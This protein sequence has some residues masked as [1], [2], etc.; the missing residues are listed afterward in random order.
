MILPQLLLLMVTFG[1][2]METEAMYTESLVIDSSY[3]SGFTPMKGVRSLVECGAH[4]RIVKN[5]LDL[6]SVS[7][8]YYDRDNQTCHVGTVT[9][10]VE[11]L[12]GNGIT[13]FGLSRA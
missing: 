11:E 4:F 2:Q 6:P 7:A 9:F 8:F 3:F 13:V 10:P 5:Q 12:G 1:N